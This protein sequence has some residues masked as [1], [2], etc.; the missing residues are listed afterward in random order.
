MLK[1]GNMDKSLYDFCIA[2]KRNELL[3]QWDSA[4]NKEISPLSVS[5]FSNRKVWWICE[6]G[7]EYE[8]IIAARTNRHCACPYCCGKRLLVGF[9]DLATVKPQLA[10]EWNPSLNGSL[11]PEMATVTAL[12]STAAS[13]TVTETVTVPV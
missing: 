13:V 10:K 11:T 5:S 7:H 2:E 9:N 3:V 4:K 12:E 8:M 1:T 6:K